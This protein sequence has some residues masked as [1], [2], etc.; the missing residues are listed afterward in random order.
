MTQHAVS[1]APTVQQQEL[2]RV[3]QSDHTEGGSRSRPVS[4]PDSPSELL[5]TIDSNFNARKPTGTPAYPPFKSPEH[6]SIKVERRG[7]PKRK[8]STET[9][10]ENSERRSHT[11]EVPC[12]MPSRVVKLKLTREK[13]FQAPQDRVSKPRNPLPD[14]PITSQPSVGQLSKAP[15][16]N[17]QTSMN[18]QQKHRY[19]LQP[20]AVN[21]AEK[22]GMRPGSW[23]SSCRYAVNRKLVRPTK[24]SGAT[25][26]FVVATLET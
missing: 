16:G 24:L 26:G 20:I 2:D 11:Q 25:R 21:E 8:H 5:S 6:D 12:P 13:M 7:A 22:T 23:T 19:P 10:E 17:D 3:A 15:D 4:V 18:H 14:C 1:T 9:N